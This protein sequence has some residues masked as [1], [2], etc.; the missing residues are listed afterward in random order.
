MPFLW[1]KLQKIK[2]ILNNGKNMSLL[3]ILIAKMP[4]LRAEILN[5]KEIDEGD[6]A[7]KVLENQ[8]LHLYLFI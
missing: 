4:F 8:S 1:A 2:E 7:L 5:I 3:A 6:V